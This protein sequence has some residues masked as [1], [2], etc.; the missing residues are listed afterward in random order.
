MITFLNPAGFWA[1]AALPVLA[2]IHLLQR[3]RE[4][5]RVSTAF[6]LD[7]ASLRGAP[8]GRID[9]FRRS[10]EFFAQC[11]AAVLAALLLARPQL[12]S[13]RATL[14]FAIVIDTSASMRACADAAR[15]ETIRAANSIASGAGPGFNVRF[16]LIAAGPVPSAVLRQGSLGDLA[17]ALERWQ[18]AARG[19]S[20]QPAFELAESLAGSPARVLWVTDTA[21][22]AEWP[23]PPGGWLGVGAPAE[24]AGIAAISSSGGRW[25]AVVR[26]NS[27][28]PV[29]R[30]WSAVFSSGIADTPVPS[31][32]EEKT[33]G[34]LRIEPDGSALV[35]GQ[36]PPGAAWGRLTL[37]P[38]DEFPL[39]DTAD[40]VLPRQRPLAARIDL[41][42]ELVPLAERLRRAAGLEPAPAGSPAPPL[43]FAAYNPLE[44]AWPEGAAVVFLVSPDKPGTL[45][46]GAAAAPHRLM[47]DLE[48]EPLRAAAVLAAPATGAIEPLLWLGDRVIIFV[49]NSGSAAPQLVIN[50]DARY[51]NAARL[52]ALALLVHRFA[53]ERRMD[54]PGLERRDTAPGQPVR[55]PRPAPGAD[56]RWLLT[57]ADGRALVSGFAAG[58]RPVVPAPEEPGRFR[59]TLDGAPVFEGAARFGEPSEADLRHAASGVRLPAIETAVAAR[60]AENPASLILEAALGCALLGAL[61]ASWK[62]AR[63]A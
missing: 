53:E 23:P 29:E 4:P 25:E 63:R 44:P 7:P 32:A 47:T 49:R 50:F 60:A 14:P 38:P 36:F 22:P 56:G 3:R 40:F 12:G 19:S 55:I 2:G 26:N 30:T 8:G 58:P 54:T 10:G 46:G 37:S 1:L 21:P 15:R 20:P 24:N 61:A 39:D 48:W 11:L 5:V 13:E 42:P 52:P 27:G 33:R 17:A 28:R 31:A 57:G 59:I 35:S 51:S 6:L 34:A 41:P 16:A 43:V 45:R 62:L 9:R 18:P